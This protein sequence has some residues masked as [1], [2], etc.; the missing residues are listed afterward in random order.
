MKRALPGANLFASSPSSAA[1]Q[2][3][4]P[5]RSLQIFAAVVDAPELAVPRRELTP[6]EA[7]T[8]RRIV[9]VIATLPTLVEEERVIVVEELRRAWQLFTRKASAAA[10]RDEAIEQ[11]LELA[12]ARRFAER[13][14]RAPVRAYEVDA[15]EAGRAGHS[16]NSGVRPFEKVDRIG[17]DR[18]DAPRRIVL[19]SIGATTKTP[20][21]N[22]ADDS[23]LHAARLA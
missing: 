6:I 17:R 5:S 20:V 21:Q 18:D 1:S 19:G 8:L 3:T 11:R 7:A 23:A 4:E 13:D 9:D 16:Q 2:R 15:V 14:G 12:H 22:V 10:T